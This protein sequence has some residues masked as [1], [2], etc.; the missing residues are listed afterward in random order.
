MNANL[1]PSKPSHDYKI[2]DLGLADWGRKEILIAETEMPGCWPFG[3][4]SPRYSR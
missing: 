4:S 3:R 2:A 1:K